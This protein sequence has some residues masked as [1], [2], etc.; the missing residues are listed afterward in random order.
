VLGV[1]INGS[2]VLDSLKGSMIGSKR[3]EDEEDDGCCESEP[4]SDVELK[5][6]LVN[7]GV[8]LEDEEEQKEE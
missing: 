5:E 6:Y 7:S 8:A 2:R 4:S 1:K 3:S